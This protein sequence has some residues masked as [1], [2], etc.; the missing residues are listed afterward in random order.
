[1]NGASF[2]SAGGIG[3]PGAGWSVRSLGDFD[4][5]GK[6]D[7]VWRHTDGT[8]YLWTMNG[9]SVSGYL[10]VSNPGGTWQVVAP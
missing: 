1:M 6:D 9:A 8:T 7:L 5:D 10:S 3:N 2:V 4:G